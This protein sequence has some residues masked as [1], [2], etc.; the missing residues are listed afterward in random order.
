MNADEYL[1]RIEAGLL[2]V[3]DWVRATV[4]EVEEAYRSA[5]E[6]AGAEPRAL[7][8]LAAHYRNSGDHVAAVP[9]ESRAAGLIRAAERRLIKRAEARKYAEYLAAK[10]E[11]V[12]E[13]VV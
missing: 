10:Q 3:P 2:T 6:E 12:E 9:L 8:A 5:R 13:A 7:E 11:S 4:D 1:A